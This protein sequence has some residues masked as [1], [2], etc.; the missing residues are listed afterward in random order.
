MKINAKTKAAI[1]AKL[2]TREAKA[3]KASSK[4]EA[5]VSHQWKIAKEKGLD[6]L[7]GHGGLYNLRKE[8]FTGSLISEG[9]ISGSR[10]V[11]IF[12]GSRGVCFLDGTAN[13]K[14][15]FGFGGYSID[16]GK[17][18]RVL[19]F[20]SLDGAIKFVRKNGKANEGTTNN[21]ERFTHTYGIGEHYNVATDG[22][23]L[24][25]TEET[26]TTVGSKRYNYSFGS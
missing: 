4:T 26:V 19:Y 10:Q 25:R 23:R 8:D 7:F 21:G 2:K 9:K 1:K 15:V 13:G 11:A 14:R 22:K 20:G 18:K 6:R 3:S 5:V 17:V 12:A 16:L 24:L